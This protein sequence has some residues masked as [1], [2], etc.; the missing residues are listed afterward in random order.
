LVQVEQATSIRVTVV[1][2]KVGTATS[3]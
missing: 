2:Q 3:H 1:V